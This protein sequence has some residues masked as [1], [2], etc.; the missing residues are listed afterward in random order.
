[1]VNNANWVGH[2]FLAW[3]FLAVRGAA[4]ETER[5]LRGDS[6]GDFAA[7]AAALVIVVIYY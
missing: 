3:T 4:G 1:M 5:R 7:A 6:L 2:K